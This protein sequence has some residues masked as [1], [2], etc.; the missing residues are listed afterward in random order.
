MNAKSFT[1]TTT[2][3]DCS[4]KD[5]EITNVVFNSKS[6]DFHV[7][8]SNI[9]DVFME[10]VSGDLCLEDSRFTNIYMKSTSG[11]VKIGEVKATSFKIGTVSGDCKL[12]LSG[13]LQLL[14][15]HTT[16]G[17]V[18][19]TLPRGI[20]ATIELKTV[21]GD[22]NFSTDFDNDFR[23]CCSRC[24]KTKVGDGKA[25]VCINTVTGDIFIN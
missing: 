8:K 19:I 4:L 20:G 5:C 13:E 7:V 14:D 25:V 2:S 23:D 9:G 12:V 17:D 11:D 15:V 18:D 24:M 3:G 1:F 22:L 6:G 21:S 10:D 16:S